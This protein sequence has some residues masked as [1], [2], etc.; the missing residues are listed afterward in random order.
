[1]RR[2]AAC[3]GK[4]I[5]AENP[6]EKE[7]VIKFTGV[8]AGEKLEEQMHQS[9]EILDT[10]I[11]KIKI[12]LDEGFEANLRDLPN[13]FRLLQENSNPYIDELVSKFYRLLDAHS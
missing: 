11:E 9:S 4:K 13:E 1:M 2:I 10:D 3:L 8:R 7:L 6:R 12:G 5:V